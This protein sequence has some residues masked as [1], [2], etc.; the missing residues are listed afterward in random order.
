MDGTLESSALEAGTE[1]RVD[2]LTIDGLFVLCAHVQD[3]SAKR[4]FH[5]RRGGSLRKLFRG[6][7][8]LLFVRR[9]RFEHL[10]RF[11]ELCIGI[12]SAHELADQVGQDLSPG[13]LL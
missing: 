12:A 3:S 4:C 6:L 2:R 11:V 13:K 9:F 1:H 5:K 8:E 10:L 7:L